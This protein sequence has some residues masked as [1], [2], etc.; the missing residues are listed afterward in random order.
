MQGQRVS[1]ESDMR[2]RSVLAGRLVTFHMKEGPVATSDGRA[3]VELTRLVVYSRSAHNNS[4]EWSWAE[5][6]AANLLLRVQA[7]IT[8]PHRW[9]GVIVAPAYPICR[10]CRSQLHV[11]YLYGLLSEKQG[12]IWQ[13]SHFCR[14]VCS[15]AVHVVL[16]AIQRCFRKSDRLSDVL[17]GV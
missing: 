14:L 4:L 2:N 7:Q 13:P 16:P 10:S 1:L 17:S 8:S 5:V 3:Y 15:P 9:W 6:N 12:C 11:G